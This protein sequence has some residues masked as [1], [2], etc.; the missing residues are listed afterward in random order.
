VIKRRKIR[1]ENGERSSE[2]RKEKF[3]E[4]FHAKAQRRRDAGEMCNE[5]K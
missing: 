2:K 5:E 3:P 4:F 1:N